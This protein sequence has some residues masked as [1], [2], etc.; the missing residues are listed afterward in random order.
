MSPASQ[1]AATRIAWIELGSPNSTRVRTDQEE[2]TRQKT[3]DFADRMGPKVMNGWR[4]LQNRP[5]GRH[6]KPNR[7]RRWHSQQ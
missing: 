3:R 5:D 4:C 7:H 2:I 6:S 1:M